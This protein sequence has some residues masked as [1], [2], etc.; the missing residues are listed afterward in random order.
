MISDAGSPPDVGVV[1]VAAGSGV[2]AGPGEPKQFRTIAGVPMLLRAV[3]PFA[4]H[5]AVAN[6]V[7]ALPPAVATQPPAWLA[8]LGGNRLTIVAGGAE[9]ADSVRAALQALPEH[10]AIV[11]VHDA[12]RPFVSREVIDAVIAGA[13]S[14]A[15]AVAAIPVSDT[16]KEAGAD[17]RIVRSVP[18]D[19]LWRAQTPQGF[20]RPMLV[21]AYAAPP[22]DPA[23]TDDADWCERAGF[24]V[25]LVA[26]SARNI[27]VT[28]IDDFRTAEALARDAT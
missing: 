6:V 3:R 13:R 18:R 9:R 22:G 1:L 2:R 17:G 16:L 12:A 27:K 4:S 25:H 7:I 24:A 26:D 23:A 19:R 5:P 21:A 20:P 10:V 14:G 8:E 15:G 28:T 11:L